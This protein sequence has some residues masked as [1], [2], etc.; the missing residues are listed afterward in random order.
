MSQV[1]TVDPLGASKSG[2]KKISSLLIQTEVINRSRHL[3]SLPARALKAGQMI[4]ILIEPAFVSGRAT[5]YDAR[6]KLLHCA[7]D[8][9]RKPIPAMIKVFRPKDV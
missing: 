8:N 4:A 5:V 6:N 2:V 1:R 9:L 3:P 7:S